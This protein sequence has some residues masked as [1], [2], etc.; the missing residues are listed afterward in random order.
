[1]V[2]AQK[3]VILKLL[4]IKRRIVGF[5]S[6][7]FLAGCLSI[8]APNLHSLLLSAWADPQGNEPVTT[9]TDPVQR[10]RDIRTNM[11]GQDADFIET[12]VELDRVQYIDIPVAN[13]ALDVANERFEA[14]TTKADS[15]E[16][17]VTNTQEQREQLQGLQEKAGETL[18]LSKQIVT[19]MAREEMR[20]SD[21]IEQARFIMG[22]AS[23][24]GFVDE[25]QQQEQLSQ[26]ETRILNE[27]SM[28][29]AKGATVADR[30]KA[31]DTKLEELKAEG[32]RQLKIA[33]DAKDEADLQVAKLATLQANLKFQAQEFERIAKERAEAA[34]RAAAEAA[35]R[36]KEAAQAAAASGSGGNANNGGDPGPAWGGGDAPADIVA[37]GAQVVAAAASYNGTPYVYAGTSYDGID[38]SGLT[39]RAYQ[40]VGINL[41]HQSE[42]QRARGHQISRDQAVPGDL[43]WWPGHV[44]IYVGPGIMIDAPVPGMTVGYHSIW[45]SPEYIRL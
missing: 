32:L 27:T 40:A 5:V 10:E 29:Y 23:S 22:A 17:R 34:A 39:M 21:G 24:E 1:M 7:V 2:F 8:V 15:I 9:S 41:P 4:S 44:A 19:Q 42:S 12:A 11:Q 37:R 18:D 38:C 26:T 30:L 36:A 3:Y 43:M 33:Q 35:Q 13:A 6:V 28:Q 45:G 20:D 16:R 25:I 31:L 14:A